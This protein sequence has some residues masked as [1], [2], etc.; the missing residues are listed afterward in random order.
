MAKMNR[1][2]HRYTHAQSDPSVTNRRPSRP[3]R[4][5]VAALWLQ[6]FNLQFC[7][8]QFCSSAQ[9]SKA[10]DSRHSVFADVHF[11]L[12][13]LAVSFFGKGAANVQCDAHW[14]CIRVSASVVKV[15]LLSLPSGLRTQHAQRMHFG[16]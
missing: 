12:K 10:S 9:R 7:S 14:Y 8:L 15:Q 2:L 5:S 3:G 4:P 11:D 1:R 6:V 16:V 13:I